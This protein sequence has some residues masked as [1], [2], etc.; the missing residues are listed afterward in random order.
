MGLVVRRQHAKHHPDKPRVLLRGC[1]LD[2]PARDNRSGVC[3]EVDLEPRQ[4]AFAA[5]RVDHITIDD[6]ADIQGMI[7]DRM[8]AAGV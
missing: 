4:G 6:S 1:D 8:S 2:Q 3:G 5:R 7:A